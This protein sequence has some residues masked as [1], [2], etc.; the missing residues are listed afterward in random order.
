MR[1]AVALRFALIRRLLAPAAPAGREAL[2]ALEA[3][4][5][6]LD[7][8]RIR[9]AATLRDAA[10]VWGAMSQRYGSAERDRLWSHPDLLPTAADQERSMLLGTR[11]LLLLTTPSPARK[12]K[13]SN[14]CAPAARVVK[15][16]DTRDL[17]TL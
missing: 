1:P 4:D 6:H 3:Q 12:K 9:V 14:A 2:A 11:R 15:L 7:A 17:K 8:M 10:T 16:V 13:R 5:V